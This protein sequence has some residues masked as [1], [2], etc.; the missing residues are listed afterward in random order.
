MIL[1][2]VNESMKIL[3]S[4]YNVWYVNIGVSSYKF[5]ATNIALISS[6]SVIWLSVLAF[7]RY[8]QLLQIKNLHAPHYFDRVRL[9]F[10]PDL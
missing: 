5:S 3:Y 6:C 7:R 8:I 4:L 2:I 1:S 9:G 10:Y